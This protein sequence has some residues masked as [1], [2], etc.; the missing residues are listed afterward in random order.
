MDPADRHDQQL[1]TSDYWE[2]EKVDVRLNPLAPFDHEGLD[3]FLEGAEQLRG[4]VMFTTSG[5]SG[6]PKLVC[7]SREALLA[8]A[9]SVN[10]HIKA[11]AEDRWLC[12]LPDFHVGGFGVW[13]RAWRAG[14]D[15]RSYA[16][17]WSADAFLAQCREF[18]ATLVSL[19]PVQIFDLVRS[20]LRCPDGLRAVIVG[21]GALS[22][23]LGRA[24]RGLGWPVLQTYGMTEAASQVA[25]QSLDS[26][27]KKFEN[28]PLP[29]IDG[30]EVRA[31]G[32][33]QIELRGPWLFSGYVE[34]R[35]GRW[36]FENGRD[37]E[38][39]FTTEDYGKLENEDGQI[40][41]TI[42]GR[43]GRTIKVLGELVNLN[44]IEDIVVEF[45]DEV[46]GLV[47]LDAIEDER[48]GKRIILVVDREVS[49]KQI[50]DLVER[51][52][53]RVAPFERI[54]G[55]ARVEEIP[56]SPLGKV[57]RRKLAEMRDQV[58]TW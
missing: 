19:V 56:R 5:T 12:A 20:N 57:Q 10:A 30:W 6:E 33:G 22:R 27:G 13:A 14:G 1:L 55:V 18:R 37:S 34:R 42:V 39:W 15:A 21:G 49:R 36:C 54:R 8:S 47:A 17:S 7:L 48:T 9:D 50:Q 58:V 29:A 31:D 38:G 51:V 11:T 2:S 28:T 32:G 52:N 23:Q 41:L 4:H 40:L 44:R 16:G 35:D 46:G 25:T 43:S 3:E 24:A 26:L 53:E 45:A